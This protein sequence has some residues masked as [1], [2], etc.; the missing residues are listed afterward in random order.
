[1]KLKGSIVIARNGRKYIMVKHTERAWEFPGGHIEGKETPLEAA[2]RELKEETGLTGRNWKDCGVA[3]L[4]N[5]NLALFSCNVSGIPEPDTQE[6]GEAR[7]FTTPPIGL[8][9]ERHEYFLLLEMAGWEPK[10]KTDYD[11]ASKEFDN[12]RSKSTVH[13]DDWI[14]SLIRWGKIGKNTRVLDAGCGTG[15]YSLEIHERTGANVTGID[16]SRGM[17][18]K[19]SQKNTG[20]WLQGDASSLPFESENFDT[21]IIMLVLQHVD[22]EPKVISEAWRVLKPGGQLVIVTV[23]HARI[24]R[25]IMRHFPGLVKIDLDRFMPVPELKWHLAHLGFEN[26]HHHIVRSQQTEA[27]IDSL[28]HR[29]RNRYISTLALV[30]EGDFEKNLA[31]F[32]K[33]LRK[34]YG[35]TVKSNVEMVFIESRKP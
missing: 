19:A 23:S 9:F 32:E 25:H 14:N 21:V 11:I 4:D 7:Y 17:L 27:S 35:E 13:L 15:R 34:N 5:G 30:P 18:S 10:K 22:D 28:I 1:M 16:F 24:R 3:E 8:S 12:I 33:E 6:I 20:I 29:F 2:K 26:V 31:I